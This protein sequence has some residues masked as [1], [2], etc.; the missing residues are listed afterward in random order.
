MV[1]TIE[2]DISLSEEKA[3]NV[4]LNNQK[5]SGHFNS[6]LAI[7]L[8]EIRLEHDGDFVRA[9]KLDSIDVPEMTVNFQAGTSEDQQRLDKV[10]IQ[11]LECPNCKQR[12]EKSHARVIKA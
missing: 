4:T 8:D 7:I 1:P 9:L 2:V 10:S 6:N 5:I 3:L 11:I 12:F